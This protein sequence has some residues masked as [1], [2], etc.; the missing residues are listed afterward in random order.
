MIRLRYTLCAEKIVRDADS[1]MVSAFDIVEEIQSPGF[2]R[3]VIRLM[4]I[5]VLERD[6]GDPQRPPAEVVL[7]LNGKEI[8]KAALNV[9]FQGVNRTRAIVTLGGLVLTEPGQFKISYFV[10]GQPIASNDIPVT[11]IGAPPVEISQTGVSTS[12]AGAS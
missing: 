4:A 9:D 3:L 7:S 10:A 6:P 1:N 12:S 2:P 11:Q 8:H 5:L